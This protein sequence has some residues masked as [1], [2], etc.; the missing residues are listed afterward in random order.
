MQELIVSELYHHAAL[1][2][3]SQAKRLS[4]SL[5]D[6][7]SALPRILTEH[8]SSGFL[9]TQLLRFFCNIKELYL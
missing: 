5:C 3:Q 6:T 8:L 4:Q 2:K 1:A 7:H 9:A